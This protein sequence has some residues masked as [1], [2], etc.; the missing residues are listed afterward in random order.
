MYR[1][2]SYVL[3]ANSNLMKTRPSKQNHRDGYSKKNAPAL[4]HILPSRELDQP[5]TK[6]SSL[7][8]VAYGM[9]FAAKV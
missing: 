8:E 1:K 7:S 9:A 5:D 3:F 4:S 2:P 6:S